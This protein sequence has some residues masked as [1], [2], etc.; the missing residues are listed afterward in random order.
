MKKMVDTITA[1]VLFG[2]NYHAFFKII[3]FMQQRQLARLRSNYMV[4]LILVSAPLD[5]CR[6]R[7]A[8]RDPTKNIPV[9]SELIQ[10]INERAL[11][12]RLPWDLELDNS[13]DISEAT[14]VEA[15]Q[16][17]FSSFKLQLSI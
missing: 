6:E 9:S 5:K 11:K 1:V 17:K 8:H 12:V 7:M 2:R 3:L 14:I 16:S 15:F 10:F 13:V 4:K